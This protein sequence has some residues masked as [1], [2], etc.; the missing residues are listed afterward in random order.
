LIGEYFFR[1]IR[2]NPEFD[3]DQFTRKVIDAK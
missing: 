2:L 1:N 3:R